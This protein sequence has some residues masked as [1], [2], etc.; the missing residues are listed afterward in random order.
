MKKIRWFEFLPLV[1]LGLFLSACGSAAAAAS[2]PGISVD[3][4]SGQV[5]VAYNQHVYALQAENGVERWRF[6]AEPQGG[7]STFAAP[8]LSGDGQLIVGGYDNKLYSIN[9]ETGVQ[10]W[11]FSG[12][13]NRYIASA[14]VLPGS[15]FAPNADYKLYKLSDDGR[16]QA[17][18]ATHNPQ[19]GQPVT[20]GDHVYLASMD[21]NLVALDAQSVEELWR[22]E[23]GGTVVGSPLLTEEGI[24]YVGTLNHSVVAVDTASQKEMWRFET[25]GW[26]WASPIWVDGR[27]FVGDLDGIFYALDGATGTE[28]WRVDT[29]GAI[30]GAAALFA[31]SLYV[32]N[33]D[34][35]VVSLSLDGRSR[36]LALPEEYRGPL[37]GSPV[38]AGDLLLIGLT[39]N[40][41][42]IIALDNSGAVVWAFAPQS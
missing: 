2:W 14:L 28:I 1:L 40:T 12:A 32:I 21:Q 7:F 5:Y 15:I 31:D 37:Y 42:L 17:T 26:V 39:N 36:E 22:L 8:V 16:L 41:N 6:P 38:V 24:L 4:A 19:W 18:F 13:T 10:N 29:G 35:R 23:L 3:E 27:V 34:G 9:P 11:V 30:T 25:E 33:E 20:D